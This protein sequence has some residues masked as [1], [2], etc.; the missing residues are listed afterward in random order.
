VTKAN[1][2]FGDSD[3]A[4]LRLRNLANLYE[5]ETRLLLKRSNVN[6]PRLAIDLGCGPGW[7][8]DL[9]RETLNPQQTVGLDSSM[10]YLTEAREN[11][12]QLIEFK[13]HD[14]TQIPFP[15]DAPDLLFCRF[16]LTHLP[17]LE[18]VLAG[19]RQIAQP[20]AVLLIHETESLESESPVLTRYYEL[21]G[22]L[23]D[24]YGQKTASGLRYRII[25]E[26]G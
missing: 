16:L 23:Q 2:T 20:G 11:H 12:G 6:R 10:R 17:C 26:K 8:T 1:Y 9:I 15:T 3:E 24:H 18:K 25:H 4:S 14:V 21:V 19:W 13:L 7:S 5:P 22:Q